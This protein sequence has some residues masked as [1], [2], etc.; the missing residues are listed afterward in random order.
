MLFRSEI[1][2]VD[3]LHAAD[4][5]ITADWLG[6]VFKLLLTKLPGSTV[7]ERTSELWSQITAFYQANA[8]QDRLQNLQYTVIKQPQ[9]AAK[10][11]ASGAQVRALVPFAAEAASRLLNTANLVDEA[12]RVGTNHLAKCY[13]ALS[14]DEIGRAHV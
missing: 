7:N 8:V 12:A 3:W 13:D 4:P 9:K 14:S 11:R 5:G 1:F 10:L 2:R 6:H